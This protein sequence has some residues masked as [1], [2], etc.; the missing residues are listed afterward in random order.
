MNALALTI[1]LNQLEPLFGISFQ[2]EMIFIAALMDFLRQL[3]TVQLPVLLFSSALFLFFILLRVKGVPFPALVI[4]VISG[5]FV[6]LFQLEEVGIEKVG[7]IRAGLPTWGIPELRRKM[8]RTEVAY[9]TAGQ[10]VKSVT[11]LPLKIMKQQQKDKCQHQ[12]RLSK[13]DL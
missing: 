12:E 2:K 5:C 1:I 7:M 3:S 13:Q 10:K 11:F 4:V 6:Y 9:Q 8:E